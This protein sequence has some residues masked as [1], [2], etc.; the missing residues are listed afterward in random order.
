MWWMAGGIAL[1]VGAP[2]VLGFIEYRLG[3]NLDIVLSPRE[4][5]ANPSWPADPSR[6]VIGEKLVDFV[7]RMQQYTKTAEIVITLSSASIVFIPSHVNKRP[8][9]SC[10]LVLLGFAVVW[11]ASFIAWMSYCYEETLYD[12]KRFRNLESSIMYGLGFGALACFAFAYLI[13]AINVALAIT[14]GNALA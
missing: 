14:F 12:P 4:W 10:S 11:G 5:L 2:I 13:F 1:G 9:L 6:Y 7:P 3:R 8:A